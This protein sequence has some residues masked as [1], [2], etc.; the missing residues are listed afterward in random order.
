MFNPLQFEQ[1]LAACV[2]SI[3]SKVQSKEGRKRDQLANFEQLHAAL[4]LLR[5]TL[6]GK[7]ELDNWA[8]IGS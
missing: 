6:V 1:M 8:N 4:D 5:K 3:M 7:F 2:Q